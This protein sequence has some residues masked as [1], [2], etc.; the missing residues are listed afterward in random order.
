MSVVILTFVENAD[1]GADAEVLH[2]KIQVFDISCPSD[3]VR[4]HVAFCVCCV[5]DE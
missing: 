4:S 1:V 3:H 5:D 2:T